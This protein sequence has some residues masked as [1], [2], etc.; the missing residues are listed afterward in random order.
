MSEA[1]FFPP[2]DFS[3]KPKTKKE[4][5]KE[6]EKENEEPCDHN[7]GLCFPIQSM[8]Q[9]PYPKSEPKPNVIVTMITYFNHQK[10][11]N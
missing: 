10:D 6:K 2:Q 3:Q 11:G 8:N 1:H 5:E 7:Q 4:K 9:L